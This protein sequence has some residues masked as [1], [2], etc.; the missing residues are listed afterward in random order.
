M[1]K[2]HIN[3]HKTSFRL[4]IY[5]WLMYA[6]V[7]MTKNCFSDAMASIVSEGIMTKS[8][9]GLITALF[10]LAYAPLQIVGGRLADR[11]RP[12]MLIVIGLLGAAAG[13]FAQYYSVKFAKY[14][15]NGEVAGIINA[16][17]AMGI[18]IQ[19]YGIALVADLWNWTVVI[20]LLAAL[21]V[22]SLIL[23]VMIYPKWKNFTR[24]YDI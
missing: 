24:E 20:A 2:M 5:V 6:V 1:N 7:Y 11:W 3:D 22:I 21:C 19:S 4:F 12:D 9:T 15:K 14:G 8:Q 16:G 10:Y 23:I 13:L 18:V 17:A